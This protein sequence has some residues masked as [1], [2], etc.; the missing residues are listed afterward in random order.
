[1]NEYLYP[2]SPDVIE[3]ETLDDG[4]SK[5]W[6]LHAKPYPEY[7]FDCHVHYAGE[8]EDNIAGELAPGLAR[9]SELDVKRA[10]ILI[11]TYGEK[12]EPEDKTV[13]SPFLSP[14][15][16]EDRL[17]GFADPFYWA[18]WIHHYSPEPNLVEAVA[19]LGAS[20]I[21]LHN[22]PVIENNDPADLWLNDDW[23]AT[24]KAMEKHGLPA[25]FHVTQRLSASRYTG[26]GRNTYWSA[27]WEN[28]TT[29]TNEDLLQ[30]FLECCRRY[31]GINFLGAHQLHIGWPRLEELFA[32][33]PNLYVDSTCGCL[34][35]LHDEFYPADKAY[36]RDVFIRNAD[37]ILW[38]TDT[39]WNSKVAANVDS[40]YSDYKTYREH[41]RFIMQLDL[42]Q[43]VLDKICYK[44][45]EKLFIKKIS[46][47]S[48]QGPVIAGLTC[49]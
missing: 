2:H 16:L 6:A 4:F 19:K 30:V 21:K 25:L 47:A 27:G 9:V 34:L 18:A 37:R 40:W 44:N 31:P 41:I 46:C 22:S 13:M 1:M 7:F 43:D 38:G 39:F 45:S 42:P 11:R 23:T 49:N 5:G 3:R 17:V 35:K 20:C 32:K 12:W 33:H 29:Y 48:I 8:L 15:Q 26:G 28:G 10:L 24:F 36:L 14:A